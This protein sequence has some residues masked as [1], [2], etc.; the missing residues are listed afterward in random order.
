MPLPPTTRAAL[1]AAHVVL[2]NSVEL[3]DRIGFFEG[4]PDEIRQAMLALDA[5]KLVGKELGY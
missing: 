2:G 3:Y 4:D 1:E 5:Y